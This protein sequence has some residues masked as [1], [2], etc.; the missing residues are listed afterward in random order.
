MNRALAVIAA[1][2]LQAAGLPVR[3]LDRGSQSGIE[4]PRQVVVTSADAFAAL[5]REHSMKPAP[6]VDFTRES[7]VAVFLGVRQTAGFSVDI[8]SVTRE[9]TGTVV[10]YRERAP[11]SDA[12][13]AQVLTF[14]YVV[15]A[16]EGLTPPVRFETLRR[17]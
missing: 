1:L 3:T 9:A 10:A 13:T 6:P 17:E 11:S 5:W 12:V 2:S 14:P 8:V 7:V 16:V 15:A 4:A